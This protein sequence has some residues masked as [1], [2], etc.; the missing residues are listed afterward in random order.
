MTKD[1]S[2][3]MITEYERIST[4]YFGLRDQVNEWFKAY[5][6]VIG[7]PLTILAAVLK[8]SSD[9]E[10]ISITSIP[11]IVSWLLVI[12]AFL[13]LF[14]TLSIISMRM[15]MIL[16]ARTINIVRRYFAEK[17]KGLPK[18]LVLPKT[19]EKPPFYEGGKT[20]FW[21]VLL[22][23]ILNGAIL[24]IAIINITFANW[25]NIPI[26]C[27]IITLLHWSIYF[28]TARKNE[29]NWKTKF[30]IDLGDSQY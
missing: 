19:D 23:G 10:Q 14:V 17:E 4:A 18:Y 15:E 13:G 22:M 9:D 27:T 6:S 20:I 7:L 26:I 8:F 25:I 16:Y 30:Q 29:N 3:F 5:L 1:S 24:G 2:D 21:Q 12:V 28:L 11:S